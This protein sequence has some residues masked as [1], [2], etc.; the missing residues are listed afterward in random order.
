MIYQ[1]NVVYCSP[2]EF[3]ESGDI[4][5]I[6][7]NCELFFSIKTICKTGYLINEFV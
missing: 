5:V 1:D 3:S 6:A 4:G 2:L 7:D